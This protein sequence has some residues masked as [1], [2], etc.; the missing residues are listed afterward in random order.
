VAHARNQAARTQKFNPN[1]LRCPADTG[2][3]IQVSGSG[4]VS[5]L[6]VAEDLLD[7]FGV[8]G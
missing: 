1:R 6:L 5:G 3:P 7:D 8:L 2:K 4:L